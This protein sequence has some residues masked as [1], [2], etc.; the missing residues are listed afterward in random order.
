MSYVDVSSLDDP[1]QIVEEDD[2]AEQVRGPLYEYEGAVFPD[3][4]KRGNAM[5]F[6]LPFAL[7][8]CRGSGADVGCGDWPLPGALPVD[9]K[10]GGDA[11]ALPGNGF[12]YVFSSHCLEHLPNPVEAIEHWRDCL[13]QGGALFLYLPHPD[14]TYWRPEHCRKH[15]HLF[16]PK[17][18]AQMLKSL[19]FADVIHSERD[20]AWSF[21]VVGF[22]A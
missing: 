4:L 6:V 9:M 1:Q 10:A 21:S 3:Y 14:M 15:L 20:L 19:G 2:E 18:I 16:W 12:D 8:F 7:Q 22:K 17:D 11:L 13:R 5:Q